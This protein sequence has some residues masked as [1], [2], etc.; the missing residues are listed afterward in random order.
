[1]I[2]TQKSLT[3]TAKGQIIPLF[4]ISKEEFVSLAKSD[5]LRQDTEFVNQIAEQMYAASDE[6]ERKRL[7]D[8]KQLEKKRRLPVIVF[9]GTA[10]DHHRQN[11]SMQLNG[12]YMADFD[13]IEDVQQVISEWKNLWPVLDPER[14]PFEEM[15]KAL[16][17]HF[18]GITPSG[19]GLRLVGEASAEIGDLWANQVWLGQQLMLTPTQDPQCKDACRASYMITWDNILYMDDALFTYSN[20]EYDAQFGPQYRNKKKGAKRTEKTPAENAPVSAKDVPAKN[21]PV[22][23]KDSQ[24]TYLGIPLQT[25]IDVY[26]Q[27]FNNGQTPTQGGRDTLTFE[28]CCNLR[29]ICDFSRDVLIKAVPAYDDFP[30]CDR[31]KTIDSALAYD[32]G[33]MPYRMRKVLETVRQQHKDEPE[34]VSAFEEAAEQE[35]QRVAA[36]VSRSLPFGVKDSL[37]G[38]AENMVMPHL[39]S[40]FPVIGAEASEVRLDIHSEGFKN[41]NLQAY[42]AG[43][44][45]SNKGQMTDLFHLWTRHMKAHDDKMRELEAEQEAQF[46]KNKNKQEQ[47]ER[48]HFPQHLQSL[49]TSMTEVLYRLQHAGGR[50]LLSYGSESDQLAS[51]KG[52]TWSDM[53]VLLRKAYDGDSYEQDFKSEQSTRAWIDHVLWNVILCGTPDALYRMY[54]NYTNGDITRIIISQTPDNTYA[55]LVISK[56]RSQQAVENISQ[57]T[58][59]LP[60]MKGD[61]TLPRLEKTCQ[62]WLE[63]VRLECAKSDDRTRARLRFRI[64]V[65]VMRCTAA[66]MLCDF[67]GFL[68]REIDRKQQK[69][70][71]ADGCQTAVE[72]L[73]KHPEATAHWL[74]RKFQKRQT[75]ALFDILADYYMDKVLFYFRDRIEKASSDKAFAPSSSRMVKGKNDDIYDRLPQCFTL[76]QAQQE[77]DDKDYDRTR[78]MVKNWKR[79]GLVKS[80]DTATYEKLLD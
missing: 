49:R 53:S 68:I 35:N 77:R 10:D 34:V 67:G 70:D 17:L 55:P 40:L 3:G 14:N 63:R 31:L 46:S 19:H 4:P 6:E 61:I 52:K 32:H 27:L 39:T 59:L 26:W 57:L 65:S 44:S 37:M 56:P 36:L 22:D 75:L 71:W 18:I 33:P 28:L 69:P 66:L 76:K 25:Y 20:M 60:L 43:L 48:K 30:E 24:L 29:H 41:L 72:Y 62:Q 2:S 16:R 79:A 42:I 7:H 47:Q 78:S 45:A 12:E 13:D 15:A 23:V 11:A 9:Q 38:R 5:E 21:A 73:G 58:L 64:A 74:P 50:H 8:K 54:R 51:G 80:I 1:M